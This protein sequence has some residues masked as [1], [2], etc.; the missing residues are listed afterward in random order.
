MLSHALESSQAPRELFAW[1]YGQTSRRKTSRCRVY[2]ATV[3]AVRSLRRTF[4][5]TISTCGRPCRV[6]V[7]GS[8]CFGDDLSAGASGA[9]SGAVSPCLAAFCQSVAEA[10][11]ASCIVA[12]AQSGAASPCLAVF[13]QSVAQKLWASHIVDGRQATC[14]LSY[15]FF[16]NGRSFGSKCF[17]CDG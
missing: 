2:C 16:C 8:S 3:V 6:S 4:L 13:C 12:G 11:W 7:L 9:R 17:F 14:A 5:L 1:A 15:C 10:I